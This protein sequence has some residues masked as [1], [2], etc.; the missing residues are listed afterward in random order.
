MATKTFF[1]KLLLLPLGV[2]ALHLFL[3]VV[4]V[5]LPYALF[6]RFTM[7]ERLLAWSDRAYVVYGQFFHLAR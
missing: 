6:T 5:T 3:I 1:G 4:A 7:V 2:I